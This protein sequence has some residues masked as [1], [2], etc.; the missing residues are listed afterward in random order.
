MSTDKELKGLTRQPSFPDPNSN[1]HARVNPILR[2]PTLQ[3][4]GLNRSAA[5]TLGAIDTRDTPP[6]GHMSISEQ[7]RAKSEPE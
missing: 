6:G 7:V 1:G 2:S 5:K 3:P 4:N